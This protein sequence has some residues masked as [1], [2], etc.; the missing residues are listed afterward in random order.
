WQYFS[1][2]INH[3]TTY[4]AS[5]DHWIACLGVYR[6]GGVCCRPVL[7][8]ISTHPVLAWVLVHEWNLGAD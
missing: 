2:L 3:G 5:P 4:F 1:Y 8:S 7:A 6:F